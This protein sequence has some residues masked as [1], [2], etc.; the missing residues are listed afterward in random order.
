MLRNHH[1]LLTDVCRVVKIDFSEDFIIAAT[2]DTNIARPI[3][4]TRKGCVFVF[5]MFY[6][7]DKPLLTWL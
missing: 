6:I 5:H 1:C 3:N 4:D 2:T 7:L